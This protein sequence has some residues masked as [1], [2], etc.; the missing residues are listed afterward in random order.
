MFNLPL[1]TFLVF[2]L[3]A[4]LVIIIWLLWWAKTFR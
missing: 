4:P 2:F 3:L 1:S